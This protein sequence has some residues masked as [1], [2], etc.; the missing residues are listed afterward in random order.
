M[1]EAVNVSEENAF[2]LGGRLSTGLLSC[3][4]KP[5]GVSVER[6]M[7]LAKPFREFTWI[8]VELAIPDCVVIRSGNMTMLKS[9]MFSVIVAMWDRVPFVPVTFTVYDPA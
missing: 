5:T 3:A 2:E 6:V 1:V 7:K 4:I 9:A 8:L